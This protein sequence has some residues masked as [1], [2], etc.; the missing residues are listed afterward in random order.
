ME[1]FRIAHYSFLIHKAVDDPVLPRDLCDSK[2]ASISSAEQAAIRYLT[3]KSF[4]PLPNFPGNSTLLEI[5]A[6][7]RGFLFDQIEHRR[8]DWNPLALSDRYVSRRAKAILK[9]PP[10]PA[11]YDVGKSHLHIGMLVD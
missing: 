9:E 10:F 5:H 4:S 7:P 2:V 11:I 1:P 3:I 8:P 6:P